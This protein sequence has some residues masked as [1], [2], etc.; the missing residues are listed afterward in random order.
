MS[1][2]GNGACSALC[3]DN[4]LACNNHE[5]VHRTLW[6]DGRK[7]CSDS[8]DEWDCG[9]AAGR[10]HVCSAP[11]APSHLCFCPP[12][13]LADGPGSALTVFRTAA[14]YQVCADEWT[15]ELSRLTCDQLGLG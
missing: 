4:E 13:S 1:R 2:R 3:R 6:C 14:E 5:C 12:V 7:H 8:S 15:H 9:T 11:A 10:R